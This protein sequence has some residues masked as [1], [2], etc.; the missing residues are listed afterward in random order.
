MKW[1]EVF[2]HT[3]KEL[4]KT[5]APMVKHQVDMMLPSM[6]MVEACRADDFDF[7]LESLNP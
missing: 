3:F 2:C 5:I 1:N 6:P 4:E 7:L